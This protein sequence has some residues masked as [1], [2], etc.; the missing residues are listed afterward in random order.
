MRPTILITLGASHLGK[1]VAGSLIELGHVARTA[2][3]SG[4]GEN[5]LNAWGERHEVITGSDPSSIQELFDGITTLI[6]LSPPIDNQHDLVM[7]L[8]SGAARNGIKRVVKVSTL[9]SHIEPGIAFGRRHRTVEKALI[10]RNIPHVILR[11]AVLLD[12]L[13]SRWHGL[14]DDETLALPIGSEMVNWIDGRDVADVIA[15]VAT[16]EGYIGQEYDLTSREPRTGAD[17]ASL[18]PT[19]TG[20]PRSFVDITER[21]ARE[22]MLATGLDPWYVDGV[23]ELFGITRRGITAMV[24]A[25][26]EHL[27]GR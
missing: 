5:E 17:L 12:N 13:R 4:H 1:S 23:L 11:S 21:E 7:P 10:E 22:R 3:W 9:G 24:S 26:V 19:Q 25:T 27:L 2:V 15:E 6:L 18:F 20:Y 8:V 14:M 16:G